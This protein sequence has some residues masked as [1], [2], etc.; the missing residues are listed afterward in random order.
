MAERFS[1]QVE[2]LS[3]C[4]TTMVSIHK[5]CERLYEGMDE[6]IMRQV[7]RSREAMNS[8][9]FE[10]GELIAIVGNGVD[11]VKTAINITTDVIP[12]TNQEKPEDMSE[13]TSPIAI[14]KFL[15]VITELGYS[16]L[17][18]LKAHQ[19]MLVHTEQEQ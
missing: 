7:V 8:E 10:L 2:I 12:Y 15:D 14:N 1:R 18:R 9:L 19:K 3:Q 16:I 11:T 5:I 6:A 13:L 17:D 4:H